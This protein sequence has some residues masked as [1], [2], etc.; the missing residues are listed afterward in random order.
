MALWAP[1]L[2]HR[3]LWAMTSLNQRFYPATQVLGRPMSSYT[4]RLHF[5]L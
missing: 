2:Y 4:Q 3:D 1:A 5:D